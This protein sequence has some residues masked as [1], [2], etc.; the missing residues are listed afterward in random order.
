M[1]GKDTQMTDKL[2]SVIYR[3]DAKSLDAINAEAF[4]AICKKMKAQVAADNK[5]WKAR[6]RK[7][8]QGGSCQSELARQRKYYRRKNWS[9]R[10]IGNAKQAELAAGWVDF[11]KRRLEANMGLDDNSLSPLP[12][13]N[14]CLPIRIGMVFSCHR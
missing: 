6:I 13:I 3:C 9:E 10:H 4:D 1:W 12:A 2:L 11:D 8:E 7:M 5:R 14:P